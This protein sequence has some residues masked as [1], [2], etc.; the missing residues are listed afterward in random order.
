MCHLSDTKLSGQSAAKLCEV[1]RKRN[2]TLKDL[3]I[4]S[5][6][7]IMDDIEML[8]NASAFVGTFTSALNRV[9]FQ[10]SFSRKGYVMPFVSLDIPW[11]WAGFHLIQVCTQGKRETHR[12]VMEMGAAVRENEM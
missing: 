5:N 10:L 11:C 8:A 12:A 1:I 7:I 6:L 4:S 2:S 3:D 9:A